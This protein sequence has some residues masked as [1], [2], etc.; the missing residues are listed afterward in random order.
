MTIWRQ[1]KNLQIIK[2]TE[3]DKKNYPDP[4]EETLSS[5]QQLIVDNLMIRKLKNGLNNLKD[6]TIK[7]VSKKRLK[8][9]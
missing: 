2:A 3:E 7:E 9:K 8:S 6:A 4:R 1:Q 5:L